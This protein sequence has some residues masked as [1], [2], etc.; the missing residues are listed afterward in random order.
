[1]HVVVEPIDGTE[2]DRMITALLNATGLVRQVI[3]LSKARPG[4]EGV[5]IIGLAAEHLRAALVLL[6]EHREDT[7]LA[8]VTQILAEATLLLADDLGLDLSPGG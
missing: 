4:V 1:M 8:L 5:A 2:L 6:A 3:E 7:E